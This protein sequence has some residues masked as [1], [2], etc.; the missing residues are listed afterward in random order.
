MNKNHN[1][2]RKKFILFISLILS[3]LTFSK[4]VEID[5]HFDIDSGLIYYSNADI[6]S[7]GNLTTINFNKKD[8]KITL[9]DGVYLFGFYDN[10]DRYLFK[11][12]YITDDRDFNIYF[13]PKK[14]ISVNGLINENK[15]PLNS[16]KIT[17][18]DS[19]GREYSAV[20]NENGE[21]SLNLP[22]EKY[23]LISS[24]FGYEI[25]DS[26]TFFDFSEP[27]KSYNIPINFEKSKGKIKG[28]VLGDNNQPI[29]R[30]EILV[31]NNKNDKII[32]TD[33]YGNFIT[34]LQEGITTMKISRNG[35]NSR[36]FIAKYSREDTV[37]VHTFTLTKKTYF[38]SGTITNKILP[39][40]EQEIYLFSSN[41]ALLDK[42]ITNE[43]GNFKF[44][45]ITNERVYIYIPES[46]NYEEYK[47]DLLS[48]GENISSK[49]IT[50][51]K[52]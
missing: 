26:T 51:N 34:E 1:N 38:I 5:F 8:T 13:I 9:K 24:Q 25:S 36:G 18:I 20:T 7:I 45:N 40:K 23:Q 31:S 32:Y 44:S 6:D 39:L 46:D 47:S 15:K 3:V 28:K 52:K 43:N 49:V 33:R 27:D 50:L 17:F 22:P 37:S 14:S 16:V 12:L 48:I 35:Y 30:A 19:M 10:K 21:Y 2:N 41:G 29:P 11:K 42:I 4:E